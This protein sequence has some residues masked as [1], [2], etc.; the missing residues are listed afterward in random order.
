MCARHLHHSFAKC[1]RTGCGAPVVHRHGFGTTWRAAA[2]AAAAAAAVAVPKV[3]GC[4]VPATRVEGPG[5]LQLRGRRL[6]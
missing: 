4:A 2:A 5:L 6:A 3:P 1:I